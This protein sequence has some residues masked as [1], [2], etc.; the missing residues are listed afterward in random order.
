MKR[1]ELR[2][3]TRTNDTNEINDKTCTY[4]NYEIAV[5]SHDTF[6]KYVE[7][8]EEKN[9]LAF[10][11]FLHAETYVKMIINENEE[12]ISIDGLFEIGEVF[13]NILV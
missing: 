3:K 12:L 13:S 8:N 6:K 2:Y 4:N 11:E 1:Y 10:E 7:L 9:I 5:A